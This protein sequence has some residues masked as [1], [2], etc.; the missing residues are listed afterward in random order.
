MKVVVFANGPLS[1]HTPTRRH[2]R[3]AALVIAVD[4]GVRH[5]HAQGVVP[6]I[7]VGD[8]DSAAPQDLKRFAEQG[9]RLVRHPRRKDKTDLALALELALARHAGEIIVFGA[10]GRRWDMS[11]ANLMLLTDTAFADIRLVLID[12]GTRVSL[13]RG[14]GGLTVIGRPGDTV[15]FIPAGGPARG[16]TL[17]GFDYPLDRQTIGE[18]STLGISNTLVGDRGVVRLERGLLFCVVV[19]KPAAA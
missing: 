1:A 4:G 6:G 11:L 3:D 19:K 15:S 12:G 9:T 7:L 17:D 10:L 14:G 8:M 2:L 18:A 16:V 5:C 13:L